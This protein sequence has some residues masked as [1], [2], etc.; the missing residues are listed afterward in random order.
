MI[1]SNDIVI[2]IDMLGHSQKRGNEKSSYS[3]HKD[4]K[5]EERGNVDIMLWC[6]SM[7]PNTDIEV[8]DDPRPPSWTPSSV[9]LEQ[10]THLNWLPSWQNGRSGGDMLLVV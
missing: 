7:S 3:L 9:T 4:I 6:L 2:W 8:E 10:E 1:Q 5:K